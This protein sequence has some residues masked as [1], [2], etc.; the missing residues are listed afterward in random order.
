MTLPGPTQLYNSVKISA[1]VIPLPASPQNSTE[2]FDGCILH[3]WCQEMSVWFSFPFS[4]QMLKIQKFKGFFF[5]TIYYYLNTHSNILLTV[6]HLAAGSVPARPT[7][8]CSLLPV[9]FTGSLYHRSNPQFVKAY[10]PCSWKP[11]D[12]QLST[13]GMRVW[14]ESV[15]LSRIL[16]TAWFSLVLQTKVTHAL[17]PVENLCNQ[18]LQARHGSIWLS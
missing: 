16:R 12:L 17:P 15:A 13:L 1:W 18:N 5:L 6:K 4:A 3:F 10:N 11:K 14:V 2:E 9:F 8:P 7:S